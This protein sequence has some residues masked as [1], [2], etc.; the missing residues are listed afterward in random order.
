MIDHSFT[1]FH[2]PMEGATTSSALF[3]TPLFMAEGLCCYYSLFDLPTIAW[4]IPSIVLLNHPEP[5]SLYTLTMQ[6]FLMTTRSGVPICKTNLSLKLLQDHQNIE[7]APVKNNEI[8][9]LKKIK[10][11]YMYVFRLFLNNFILVVYVSL[12]NF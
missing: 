3:P 9:K 4:C 7:I 2:F 5:L 6:C 10:F 1:Y 12:N 11:I 8:F